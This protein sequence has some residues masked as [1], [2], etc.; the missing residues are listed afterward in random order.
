ML[1][2]NYT[3]DLFRDGQCTNRKQEKTLSNE[4]IR[5]GVGE[6][7]TI[8]EFCKNKLDCLCWIIVAESFV[9]L[10]LLGYLFYNHVFTTPVG[11]GAD[12]SL[13]IEKAKDRR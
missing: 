11:A 5:Q 9:I 10:V 1:N 12:E 4:S 3:E 7:M 2:I 13:R 8:K 6:G